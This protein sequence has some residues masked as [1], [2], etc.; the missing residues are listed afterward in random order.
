MSIV[1]ILGIHINLGQPI[2]GT[3]VTVYF[4]AP[5]TVLGR[6]NQQYHILHLN[7]TNGNPSQ[8]FVC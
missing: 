4:C 2:E 7:T 6:L 1:L 3:H 5:Q 8:D